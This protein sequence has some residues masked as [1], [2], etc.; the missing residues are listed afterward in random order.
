[1]PECSNYRGTRGALIAVIACVY[2][3]AIPALPPAGEVPRERGKK[4]TGSSVGRGRNRAGARPHVSA[5]YRLS[6]GGFSPL[7]RGIAAR[8]SVRTRDTFPTLGRQRV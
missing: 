5:N 6:G 1:V 2:R 4:A 7:A 8:I 3:E